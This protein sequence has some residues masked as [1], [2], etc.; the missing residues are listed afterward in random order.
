[1]P[2][3]ATKSTWNWNPKG[4]SNSP[5][6]IGQHETAVTENET[7]NTPFSVPSEVPSSD[8]SRAAWLQGTIDTIH[9]SP[10]PVQR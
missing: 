6:K 2:D 4:D 5:A 8:P 9:T 3:A 10:A 1:M 7:N